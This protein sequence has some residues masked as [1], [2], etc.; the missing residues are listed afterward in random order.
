MVKKENMLFELTVKLWNNDSLINFAL[1]RFTFLMHLFRL[2]QLVSKK[3]KK[4][5]QLFQ[6]LQLK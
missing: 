4:R 1:M 2:V 3:T 5:L 6:S